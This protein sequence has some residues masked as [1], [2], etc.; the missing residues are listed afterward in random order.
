MGPIVQG[1]LGLDT[2]VVG[3]IKNISLIFT[4]TCKQAVLDHL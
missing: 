3:L 4:P 1:I 2:R